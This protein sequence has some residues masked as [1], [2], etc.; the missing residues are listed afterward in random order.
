VARF[1]QQDRHVFGVA[2]VIFTLLAM[3]F[4]VAAFVVAAQAD[5]GGG[6][7]GAGAVPVRLGEFFIEPKQVSVAE[8]GNLFVTNGGS[9]PHNLAIEGTDVTT[10]DLNG[11]ASETLD[12]GDLAAGAYTMFCS[13]P[14]HR[15]QG[16]VGTLQVGGGA[17]S[18]PGGGGSSHA[19]HELEEAQLLERN[20]AM[21]ETQREPVDAFVA[22]VTSF[23]P[24]TLEPNT[25]GI[26]NQ[27]MEPDEILPDGTKV[28]ELTASIIDWEIEPGN[29]V[30]AWAYNEQV[31][32]PWIKLAVGDRVRVVFRNE[33]PQSSAIHFH[34]FETPMAMDGVPYVTQEPVKPGEEF[35][36]E[37]VADKPQMG[38]Y[39]SHH[40]AEHQV[41]NGLLGIMQ[42]GDV[43]VPDGYGMG[44]VA[45]EVP[46]VLN[47]AGVIGLSLNGKSFPATLP[48]VGKV[49][50]TT[51]IHYHNE[52]LQIHPMHLHGIPQLVVAK[53]GITLEQPYWT[54]TLNVAPG[55]RFTVLVRPEQRHLGPPGEDG[56]P[57]PGLWA[58]HCHILTHAETEAGMR[59][60]VTVFAVL[61]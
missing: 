14:G 58:Y 42:V 30:R 52:G 43:P 16:M 45:Q 39:H 61:P 28:F 19:V 57:T 50:E 60:M 5:E 13:I 34:G 27:V 36:Y 24:P 21:D 46:M 6:G 55:E 35:V 59:Y 51:A 49:G 54:D 23:D 26:G 12:L 17:G 3:L 48:V 44:P 25:A 22:Q 2:T 10:A 9:A 56:R 53:D 18:E 33:L 15:E 20:D 1:T 29:V 31:P 32:G 40:H 47:D 11:G 37:F 4:S 7:G 41:P 38:M 8:G